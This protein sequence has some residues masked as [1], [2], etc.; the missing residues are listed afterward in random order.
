MR[1]KKISNRI[2]IIGPTALTCEKTRH[3]QPPNQRT[4]SQRI[5]IIKDGK[6]I[7]STM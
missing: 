2:V 4:K 1:Q 5:V 6:L 3:R 7:R